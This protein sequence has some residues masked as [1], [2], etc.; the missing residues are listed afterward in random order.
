MSTHDTFG[1]GGSAAGGES[2]GGE[3]QQVEAEVACHTLDVR[4]VPELDFSIGHCGAQPQSIKPGQKMTFNMKVANN[5]A[6]FNGGIIGEAVWFLDGTEV[7]RDPEFEIGPDRTVWTSVTTT[8]DQEF[9]EAQ[10]TARF[11]N[12]RFKNIGQDGG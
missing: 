6:R 3:A 4:E 1:I 12:V 8:V 7:A 2:G 10:V 9:D 5:V 11:E